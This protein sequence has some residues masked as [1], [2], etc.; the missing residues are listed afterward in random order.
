MIHIHLDDITRDELKS[1]R[2]T[3]LPHKV[4]DRI[5]M[6]ALSD[7]GWSAPKIAAHL[8]R[9]PQTVRDLLVVPRPWDRGSAS[10][11]GGRIGSSRDPI[12]EQVR[13]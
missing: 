3:D 5:E 7:A 4:R 12:L 8:G 6:V 10:V 11:S 1:P 9:H 2:R 13:R